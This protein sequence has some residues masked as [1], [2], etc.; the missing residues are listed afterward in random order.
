M[1]TK[2]IPKDLS[3]TTH[4]GKVKSERKEQ[5][6]GKSGSNHGSN[7]NISQLLSCSAM[8]ATASSVS[9]YLV[10]SSDFL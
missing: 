4:G 5:K 8:A 10:T 2:K 7:A 9:S 6:V 1:R 3:A